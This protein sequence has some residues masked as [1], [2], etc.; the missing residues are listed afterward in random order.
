[1]SEVDRRAA[2][3]LERA[4]RALL[5]KNYQQAI[6]LLNQLLLLPPN[7]SSQEAQ[8]LIGLAWERAGNT[9]KAK[10]EYELYLRLFPEGEGA[11][12]VAQRL[13]A[14]G[15][16]QAPSAPGATTEAKPA[17]S[18]APPPKTF[19]GSLA[20]YYYGGL[21]R[22]QTL[23]NV[24]AGV[25]QQT[26][27]RTPQSAIIT[28]AD[29][30][31]RYANPDSETRAVVRGTVA[32][33][34]TSESH[35]TG[36]I[37]S[38][39]LDYR[40]N[41]SGIGV[42][43]GRQSAINGGLLG[44]F[45]GASMVYPVRPGIKVSLMGGVP[46]N[47]LINAPSQRLVAGLVEA[48]G[49]LDH[50]GG[51]LY[52]LDQT[53]ESFTNR[54]ALGAEIRYSADTF[55]AYSLLD[56]D[57]NFK[58]LNAFTLQ[59]SLQAPG[60][61]TITALIDNRKA[62][63]LQLTNALITTGQTS[64]K[65]YLASGRSLDEA[66]AAAQAITA[67]ARQ[68]LLS[69]SRPISERWQV[70]MDLRYSQIGALPAVGNFEATP[71]TGAQTA[72]TAQLTGTNL[73]SPRDINTFGA[74]VVHSPLLNGG[75]LSYNNLTAFSGNDLTLEPSIRFYAQHSNDGLK[76]F[77]VTPGLRASYRMSLKASLIGESI[78]EYSKTDSSSG[79]SKTS[80]VFFYVGYRYDFN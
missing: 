9:G 15:A 25:D 11:T 40:R 39:Y 60:Q 12:R 56:Y 45:D 28:S 26:V 77:R 69:V 71:A 72:A 10:T 13:A 4:R 79:N 43:V 35:N 16:D 6:D 66:I 44:L 18:T 63:S 36:L 2:E 50:W 22:S 41:E 61:T 42:R 21:A 33:N 52:V 76:L 5:E 74:S 24:V 78:V 65:D 31:A 29:L 70:G 37:N 73:Y 64:L 57:V 80:S 49:L 47:T 53:V 3:L 55:S 8:E 32:N 46:A 34:L 59:G 23:V 54:R 62:P 17:A 7:P 30:N 58:A 14:M 38:A 67:N 51:S 27:T 1:L 75:Q 48:D 19:S 20:Q 68:G